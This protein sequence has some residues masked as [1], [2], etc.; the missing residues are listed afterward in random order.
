M[1]VPPIGLPPP[2]IEGDMKLGGHYKLV[3]VV[4]KTVILAMEGNIAS[5]KSR[6]LDA[7]RK[8]HQLVI[9]REPVDRWENVNDSGINLLQMFYDD[10]RKNALKLQTHVMNTMFQLNMEPCNTPL[11][12]TERSMF[13]YELH[14]TVL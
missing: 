9:Q 4:P 3:E 13:R 11:K 7:L 2:R 6:I 1:A 12:I 14:K 10:E 8:Y 5:G